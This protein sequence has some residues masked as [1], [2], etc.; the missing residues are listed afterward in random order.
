M[1]ADLQDELLDPGVELARVGIQPAQS[2]QGV[3]ALLLLAQSGV[4]ELIAV[5]QGLADGRPEVLFLDRLVLGQPDRDHVHHRLAFGHV[6]RRAAGGVARQRLQFLQQVLD[7]AV[8][9]A[10]HRDRVVV[11]IGVPD[12]GRLEAPLAHR[13]A[14]LPV[15]RDPGRQPGQHGFPAR[16]VLVRRVGQVLAAGQQVA[17]PGHFLVRDRIAAVRGHAGGDHVRLPG[18]N[19]QLPPGRLV[20]QAVV[21]Q[22]PDLFPGGHPHLPDAEL[23]R[24]ATGPHSPGSARSNLVPR[25]LRITGFPSTRAGSPGRT[26]A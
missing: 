9:T 21:E 8:L 19:A 4:R 13:G 10:Q 24:D 12:L 20:V 5:R 7:L 11:V 2:G 6:L 1:L 17:A 25:R 15:G 26:P 22:L 14:H 3:L 23:R 18:G 16:R